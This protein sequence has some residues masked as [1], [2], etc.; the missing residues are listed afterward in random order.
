[1]ALPLVLVASLPLSGCGSQG[2]SAQDQQAAAAKALARDK[3]QIQQ[4]V[5]RTVDQD[6]CVDFSAKLLGGRSVEECNGDGTLGVLPGDYK[7]GGIEVRGQTANATLILKPGGERSYR[8]IREQ[9]KWKIDRI[10][11]RYEGKLG[12]NFLKTAQF[13]QN[14]VD[15]NQHMT[16]RLLAIKD[17]ATPPPYNSPG[18]GKR[19]VR[20]K[21]RLHSTGKDSFNFSTQ[22][23]KLITCD[24]GRYEAFGYPF[25]EVPYVQA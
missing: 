15:V 21:M 6:L 19:W 1:M 2:A 10:D 8:L 13:Q 5:R 17:P 20:I 4:A 7:L 11:D 12:D 3:A 24:G 16:I 14:G 22:D 23:I 25:E 9:G 18:P